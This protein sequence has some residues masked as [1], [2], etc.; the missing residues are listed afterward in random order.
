V[1]ADRACIGAVDG[2]HHQV[3][4]QCRG[5]LA[6]RLDQQAAQSL[7]APV[8]VNVHRVLDGGAKA[9]VR[10]EIPKRCNACDLPVIVSHQHRIP[11]RGAQGQPCGAVFQRDRCFGV[12]RVGVGNHIV[13]DVDDGRQ[14]GLRCVSEQHGA[15]R[16]Q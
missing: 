10:P 12:D 1:Q 4:A 5:T 14:V 13:V 3:L 15:W 7:A 11:L 9:R 8:A 2:A 6:E 16:G